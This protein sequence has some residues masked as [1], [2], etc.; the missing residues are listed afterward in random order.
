VYEREEIVGLPRSPE[1][2][3]DCSEQQ[4]RL[5]FG[6]GHRR[7]PSED[8]AIFGDGVADPRV[9]RRATSCTEPG[10]AP[11]VGGDL[12]AD[13]RLGGADHRD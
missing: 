5:A 7:Q 11:V 9:H 2:K 12:R 1:Q 3:A 13:V 8:G 6:L 4:V 10:E